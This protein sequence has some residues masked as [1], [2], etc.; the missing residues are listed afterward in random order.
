[1]HVAEQDQAGKYPDIDMVQL[2]GREPSQ[3]E[4]RAGPSSYPFWAVEYMYT[5]GQPA[6][7]SLLS[8]FVGYMFTDTAK[9]ILQSYSVIPCSFTSLCP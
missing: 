2:G 1:M 6:P 3:E 5:D 9:S 7:G 4:V 8:E